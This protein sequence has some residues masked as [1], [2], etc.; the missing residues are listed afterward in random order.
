MNR[1]QQSLA[2]WCGPAF[3]AI[4]GAGFLLAGFVPPLAPSATPAQVAA[5]YLNHTTTIRVGL[6]IMLF[7]MALFIPWVALISE[8]L[9]RIPGTSRTLVYTQLGAGIGNTLL[10]LLPVLL[11]TVTAFRP[12]RDPNI[13]FMLN[14]LS[15]IVFIMPF[16]LGS[17]QW[18]AIAIAIFSD[19]RDKPMFPRWVGYYHVF[20]AIAFETSGFLT[21]FKTGPL[22][23]NGLLSFYLP[24]LI[25]FVWFV[26]MFIQLR[27]AIA[28]TDDVPAEQNAAKVRPQ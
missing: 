2:L 3:V 26:L 27:R 28:S 14:D 24:F 16:C 12:D 7:A 8:Q 22:A 15:W 25:F 23:W 20:V 4:F 5:F 11:F 9:K 21:F 10:I 17:L 1:L 6:L 13:T 19:T 18:L